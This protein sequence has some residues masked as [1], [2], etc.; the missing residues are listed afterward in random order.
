M[1]TGGSMGNAHYGYWIT[2]WVGSDKVFNYLGSGINKGW[3][4]KRRVKI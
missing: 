3:L 4:N 1:V 2:R